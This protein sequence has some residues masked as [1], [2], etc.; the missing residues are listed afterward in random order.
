MRNTF[1]FDQETVEKILELGTY[2]HQFR[3]EQSMSL[4]EVAAKTKIQVRLLRAIEE[5]QLEQLP[6]PVY[7]QGFIKRFADALGLDGTQFASTFPTGSVLRPLMPSWR[8]MPA[9]QLRPVHLYVL[10]IALI[11]GAVNGLSFWMNR[12]TVRT[13]N[14]FETFQKAEVQPTAGKKAAARLSEKMGPSGTSVQGNANQG[15]ADVASSAKAPNQPVRVQV[16]FK[17]QSWVRVVAD[18]KMT[19]EGV[20]P[21]GTQ[22]TWMAKEKLILRAGNA[23]GV[24]VAFNDSQAKQLGQ[25]GSVEEVTFEANSQSANLSNSPTGLAANSWPAYP[26]TLLPHN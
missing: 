23:G 4:E 19:F 3:E 7:I 16:T 14:T 15:N 9:A 26:G 8:G 21:E 5:G 17:S 24:L 2:L 1:H 6:E 18:G 10:Y 12:S 25:P 11:I 22:Q 13:A 20:L